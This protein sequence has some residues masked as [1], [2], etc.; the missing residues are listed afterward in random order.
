M[1]IMKISVLLIQKISVPLINTYFTFFAN[2]ETK[3][4]LQHPQGKKAISMTSTKYEPLKK[5]IMEVLKEH[6]PSTQKELMDGVVLFMQ[7]DKAKF[8]GSVPWHTE[9]VKLDMEARKEILRSN[10]T[11]AKYMLPGK[12]TLGV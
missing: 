10:S 2:M 6:G 8:V 11:P 7:A 3:I 4:Q 9:W 12:F 1:K 5:A